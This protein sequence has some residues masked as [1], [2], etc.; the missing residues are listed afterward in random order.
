[1][2]LVDVFAIVPAMHRSGSNL[3]LAATDLSGF[4]E[5]SHKTVLDIAVAERRLERPAQNELERRLLEQRGVEHETRVLDGYRAAGR[6][7][8]V[9]PAQ[10]GSGEEGRVAAARA[11]EAALRAGAEVVY[12]G[13]LF[14]GMWVGRPDF[15]VRVERASRL[16]AYGYEVVDAKLARHAKASAVLQL[17]TYTEHLARVQGSDPE[18][19]WIATGDDEA[20]PQPLRAADYLAYY[21]Q[22]KARMQA[23][24]GDGERA[25][26]YP[27]PIEHC[28]VCVWWGRCE[29]RRRADDHLSLVAGITRRQ[30]DRLVIA[31]VTSVA[32]LAALPSAQ[33]VA[34]LSSDGLERIREQAVLQLR[35]RGEGRILHQL[36]PEF[37]PGMGLEALPLPKPG[38]LFLDLEGDPF[39]RGEGLEYLFGL[40]ELGEPVRDFSV[41]TAPGE[42]KYRAWWATNPRE[43]KRAFEAVIDRIMDGLTEFRDLHVFHFGHRENDALKVLSCR[44]HTREDEVDELLRG[45]VLVDLHR[46]VKQ[47]LRASVE[48]YTLKQLEGLHQ[49]KRSVDRREAARSMQLFGWWLETGEELGG[50]VQELRATIER[51]NEDDC[52]STWQLREWLESQRPVLERELGRPIARPAPESGS[53]SAERDAASADTAR[54]L[55]RLTAGLPEDPERDDDEQRARR[56]L[57]NLLDWHWREAKSSWWEYYRARELPADEHV[58]DRAVLGGL[59]NV[60]DRGPVKRSHIYRY[61]FPAQEHRIREG[62]SVEDP[63]TRK[64]AGEVVGI[65]PNHLDVKRTPGR[66]H[67]AA[68]MPGGPPKTTEHRGRL[69]EIGIAVAEQGLDLHADHRVARAVLLRAPPACGQVLGAPL[70][71]PGADTVTGLSELALRLDGGVLAVQGPP[72]SGK[73]HRAAHMIAE[74]VRAGKRVGVTANS[75]KVIT[76]LIRR[77]VLAAAESG[78]RIR[79]THNPGGTNPEDLESSEYGLEKDHSRN[80]AQLA[81]GAIQVLGG[82]AWAWTRDE[83][84]GS[85]DV[86]V[87]DEAGQ[88]SLANVLAVSAAARN[89]VLFGDPAQLDQPQKGVHPVGADVS[90]LEHILGDSLTLHDSRGVFLA[91][92]RRLHP[93]ICEFT[94]AVFYEGRL[95]PIPGLERQRIIGPG[96]FEG[97]GLRFVP[98]EHRGNTNRSEEEVEAVVRMLA[99]L[100]GSRPRFVADDGTERDLME[101]DVLVVAPYN[102]QVSALRHRLPAE[103]AVGTVDKFQGQ[104]APIVVYSMASSSAA[105]APRGMEFLYS[106]N[107]LNVATSRAQALVVLVGSQELAAVRCK[108]PRQMRLANAFCSYLERARFASSS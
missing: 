40:L 72:G 42:P 30:R 1:M 36:L 108:T 18:R 71:A 61:E 76:S 49:F 47:A 31:G 99:E 98:V 67:P 15:L 13:L 103:V 74:L 52:R 75:H 7:V 94:S 60:E 37:E 96:I 21:R 3:V 102:A 77:A 100:F 41:R 78:H 38:D 6:E 25:E 19:F 69:L 10:P 68:L 66:P 50:K 54:V 105:D 97:S 2:N 58:D 85:V 55:R 51:Y 14:D 22:L 11:T 62:E 88:V 39:V 63:A 101:K 28:E 89:L 90:A 16:G 56:L 5:C 95:R 45:H 35:G 53:A 107:R 8:V 57:S 87:V 70:L 12:Q 104:Q 4:S 23:F 93:D 24:V 106:L 59:H 91:E 29:Q 80:R 32:D 82:T 43:E 92:T 46:V 83:F 34:G 33:P 79:A 27:E 84:K 26:P 86:L 48:E 20:Q 73:T 9:I 17:C 81:S 44:H 65:G 64:S